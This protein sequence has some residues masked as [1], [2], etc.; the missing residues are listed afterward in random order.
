[1]NDSEALA[2]IREALAAYFRA[3]RDAVLTVQ[4]IAQITGFHGGA[5]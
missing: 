4:T 2:Q 1:M 5:K 3:E